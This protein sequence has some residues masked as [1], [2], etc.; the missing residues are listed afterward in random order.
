M[1]IKSFNAKNGVSVGPAALP[2]ISPTAVWQGAVI[3]PSK[4]GVTN[5]GVLGQFLAKLSS[6]EGDYGWVTGI[7]VAPVPSSATTPAK[8]PSVAFDGTYLYFT[9]ADSVWLRVEGQS[10]STIVTYF[11]PDGVSAIFRA[12]GT[13]SFLRP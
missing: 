5:A 12:D 2:A 10:W 8:H 1:S 13:S 11:R 4:G 3:P 7:T 9:I 6:T